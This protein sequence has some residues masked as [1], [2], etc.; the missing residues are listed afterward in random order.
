MPTAKQPTILTREEWLALA[1]EAIRRKWARQN[2][3]SWILEFQP[4]IL[5]PGKGYIPFEPWPF[6]QEYLQDQ[7]IYKA[8]NKP[9]QCGI[10]T[11]E[12]ADCAWEI[13]H[14]KGASILVVSKDKDAAANFLKYVQDFLVSAAETDPDLPAIGK[15]NEF[16]ITVPSMASKIVAVA[17]TKSAGRSF[18]GTRLVLDEAAYQQYAYQIFHG[19]NATLAQTDG[20][21]RVIS[22]PNGRA[23]LFYDIFDSPMDPRKPG[24]NLMGFKTFDFKWWDVPS[25][26]P[27]Y[28]QYKAAK[29]ATERKHWIDK[30]KTGDWY[31]K[32][33]PK[34]TKLAWEAEFEGSFDA[35]EET[36]FNAQQLA[37]TFKENYLPRLDD[38]LGVA[39]KY[40][41]AEPAAGH[42][43]VTGVDVARKRDA[44]C[45]ITYDITEHPARL[46]EF[47]YIPAGYADWPLI[48]RSIRD[49]WA[50]YNQSEIFIDGTGSGDP[51]ADALGDIIE[52]P[53][54]FTL[55]RK[56]AMIEK[57]RLAMDNAE[58]IMPKIDQLYKEHQQY[59]WDDKQLRQ[60][61]VMANILAVAGFYEP[62]DTFVGVR[63]LDLVGD[64]P[65]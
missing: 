45:L 43:Y 30:A 23:N 5:F 34:Y 35:S 9:R 28:K 18:S 31:R 50:R 29:T 20:H 40:F 2:S 7:S 38:P 36:V 44:T 11:T 61:C 59:E 27:Y 48:E 24:L 64:T 58:I 14:V 19:A 57:T 6:Q 16:K 41:G 32:Q 53:I 49:T 13:T 22:T 60:D 51:L 54:V 1:P 65:W 62:A 25:Y 37:T 17:A 33:R 15:Q 56:Q 21:I 46:V 47:K 39:V 26:N 63:E 3:L 10:S 42:Y 12:A 55:S 52:E 4:K 8:M